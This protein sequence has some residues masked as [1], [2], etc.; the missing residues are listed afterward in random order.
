MK[1]LYLLILYDTLNTLSQYLVLF[2]KEGQQ[3]EHA[4]IMD[5]PPNIDVALGEALS[6][7]WEGRDVLRDEHSQASRGGFSDQLCRG[8]GGR[9]V[10]DTYSTSC[11]QVTRS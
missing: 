4:S 10:R 3:H 2:E 6:I 11:Y 7:G 1:C 8:E 9:G 5:D